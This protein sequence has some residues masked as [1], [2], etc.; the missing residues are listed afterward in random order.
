M[1][2]V[3]YHDCATLT[4]AHGSDDFGANV[5]EYLNAAA[6]DGKKLVAMLPNGGGASHFVF[7]VDRQKT[8]PSKAK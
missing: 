4:E 5:A 1:Y 2:I 3:E 7:E 8:S 6:K